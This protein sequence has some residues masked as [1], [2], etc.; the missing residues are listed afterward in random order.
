MVNKCIVP[1][2]IAFE[3]QLLDVI[4]KKSEIGVDYSVEK[5]FVEKITALIKGVTE[6]VTALESALANTR[7]L[8]GA[9]EQASCMREKVVYTLE[10]MRKKVDD[11]ERIVAKK[12]WPYPSYRDLLYSVK[13]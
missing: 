9:F 5:S 7:K 2:V 12:S 4:T 1:S 11:L 3:N 8:D 6:D 13:Y 10:N